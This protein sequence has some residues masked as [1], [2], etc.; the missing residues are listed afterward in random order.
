MNRRIFEYLPLGCSSLE[1]DVFPGL[2]E[3][4]VLASVQQGLFID[5]GTPEDFERAQTLR[6]Q[7]TAAAAGQSELLLS[8]ISKYPN[9]S[10][11]DPI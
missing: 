1:E 8:V 2:I 7:L 3:H 10:T 11:D 6:Q 5:I 9:K 4:G